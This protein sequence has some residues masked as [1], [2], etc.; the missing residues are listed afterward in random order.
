ML[1]ISNLVLNQWRTM[2]KKQVKQSANGW[3]SGDAVCCTHN[4]ETQDKR[5]RGG[6]LVHNEG[7]TWH[8]FNCNYST[9]YTAGKTIGLKMRHL[10][11]WLGFDDITIQKLNLESLRR[12]TLDDI[13]SDKGLANQLALLRTNKFKTHTLPEGSRDITPN[14]TK[15]VDYL[16]SRNLKVSDYNFKITPKGLARK[17]NRIIIPYMYKDKVV[18]WTSRFLDKNKPKYLNENQQP[19]YV[20]GIDLQKEDWKY[21]ILAEGIFD[22]ISIN[23]LAIMHSEISDKQIALIKNLGKEVIV[24]P[25]QDKAGLGLA[26]QAIEAGFSVSIPNWGDGIHD[27]NESIIKYGKTG[28]LLSILQAKES[29]KIKITVALHKLRKAL[30]E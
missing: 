1:E 19:G 15:F 16:E 4:G 18:G 22:A 25:D 28:T 9:A 21:V 23:G 20:F 10:L 8:C 30:Y 14:D 5:G 29:S 26:E 24:V 17:K 7:F 27:I 6:I 11:E 12:R 3:W 2:S 13:A